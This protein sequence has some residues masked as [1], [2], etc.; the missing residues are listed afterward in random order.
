VI[1]SGL[2]GSDSASISGTA[3]AGTFASGNVG[4]GIAVTANLSDLTLSNGNYYIS[5]VATALTADITAAPVTI[6][7]L[8]AATKI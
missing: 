7:G 8:T 2:L 6:S 1:A 5:D 4:T 3:T